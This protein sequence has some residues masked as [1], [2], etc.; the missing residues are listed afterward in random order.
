MEKIF[1]KGICSK[2][3]RCCKR[4]DLKSFVIVLFIVQAAEEIYCLRQRLNR[5]SISP[6]S[7][8]S[9]RAVNEELEIQRGI[10]L[11][12]TRKTRGSSHVRVD[13]F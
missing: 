8:Q 4:S 11:Y 9:G 5:A 1:Y 7:K 2:R 6:G 13:L 12:D 10:P 3:R